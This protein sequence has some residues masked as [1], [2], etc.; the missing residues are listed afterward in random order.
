MLFSRATDIQEFNLDSYKKQVFG[1][2]T[3]AKI[4]TIL[5]KQIRK[6]FGI[7]LKP[8]N[9]QNKACFNYHIKQCPGACCGEI[10]VSDYQKKMG[11]AKK[12]LSG[13]FTTLRKY[14]LREIKKYSKNQNYEQ[15]SKLKYEYEKLQEVLESGNVNLLLKLSESIPSTQNK[16]TNTLHHPKLTS[17]PKRIECYDLAHLQGTNYVGAMTVMEDGYLKKTEYRHFHVNDS[18]S[19]PYAMKEIINR[20]F[21]HLD[22]KKPDLIVLDGGKPQLNIVLPIVPANI[23]VIALAKKRETLI[24]YD[25]VGEIVEL[26]LSL[27]DPVL[28]QLILLRNEAHRFG[29]KFHR[30]QREK[31]MLI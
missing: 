10:N 7:C 6:T 18:T 17:I 27:D 20:R 4:A 13:E 31:T 8:F 2:Y 3:S 1:P 14:Y 28:N 15:A 21:A 12:F 19:D 16:I 5:Q 23:A 30:K 24:Y 11:L 25:S 29:N 9:P 22:W 26:N